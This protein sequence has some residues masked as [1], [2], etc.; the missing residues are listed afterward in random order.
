MMVL[1]RLAM[2]IFNVGYQFSGSKIPGIRFQD[3]KYSNGN[4]QT[5]TE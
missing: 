5:I 4:I 2:W 1:G 3:W